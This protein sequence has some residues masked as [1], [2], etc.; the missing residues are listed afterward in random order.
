VRLP[1]QTLLYI[2][3]DDADGRHVLLG[4]KIRGF[5]HG[6]IMAPGG[7]VEPGESVKPAAVR[8]A[9]EEVGVTVSEAD[10]DHVAVLT[11]RFPTQP[12]LDAEVHAFCASRWS[13]IVR[14]SDELEPSWFPV[15]SLPLHRMW[16]DEQYWLP[17]MLTGQRLAAHFTFDESC[18]Q[19]V[20]WSVDAPAQ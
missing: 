6:M 1:L 20:Q 13:G 5:G 10:A 7:H 19:V 8:E 18:R 15:D 3:R 17:R 4:E 16:D 12:S 14:S 2:F 11:Y 9:E